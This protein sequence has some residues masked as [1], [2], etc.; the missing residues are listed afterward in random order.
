MKMSKTYIDI[1]PK[2]LRHLLDFYTNFPYWFILNLIEK[3]RYYCDINLL[4]LQRQMER[5]CLPPYKI[6]N[7]VP[8]LEVESISDNLNSTIKGH[9][10]LPNDQL[11]SLKTFIDFINTNRYPTREELMTIN[12][13]LTNFNMIERI[14]EYLVPHKTGG[15]TY[16]F[17][18]AHIVY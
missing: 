12:L 7:I 6:C 13:H 18:A 16:R 14:V 8:K 1:L 9:Y 5:I 10:Q 17:A 15:C 3:R 2:E 4:D 11:I